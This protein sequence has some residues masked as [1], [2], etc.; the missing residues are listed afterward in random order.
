LR[1]QREIA[2]LTLKLWFHDPFD[3]EAYLQRGWEQLQQPNWADA[4]T[5]L[6]TA[7]QLRPDLPEAQRLLA[8]AYQLTG[9]REAALAA[10]SKHLERRPA[11]LDCRLQRGQVALT[12]GQPQPASEDL[13]QVLDAE[14][15]RDTARSY[16]ARAYLRLGK[17]HEALADIDLLLKDHPHDFLLHQMRADAQERLG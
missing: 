13:T 4:I 7:I 17:A 12:L 1:R 9:K 15:A 8:E 2:A 11:D 16:R 14:P 3:A 6:E 10:L 5:D